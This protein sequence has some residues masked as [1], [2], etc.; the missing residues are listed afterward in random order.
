MT[1]ADPTPSAPSPTR[2]LEKLSPV[3]G[4][5]L[6]EYPIAD[7]DAVQAAVARAKTAFPGWRDTPLEVRLEALNRGRQV[8]A[9]HA[10]RYARRIA[11]DTGKPVVE[12]GFDGGLRAALSAMGHEISEARA[13]EASGLH[14]VMLG[15]DGRLA[16]GADPRREGIVASP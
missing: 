2:M 4:A 6:G 11:E 7:R 3:T 12:A 8:L 15:A 9:E 5:R 1:L 16:G 14:A 13:G 10:E